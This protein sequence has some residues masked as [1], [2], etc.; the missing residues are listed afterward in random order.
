MGLSD[1]RGGEFTYCAE[2]ILGDSICTLY[3]L[4]ENILGFDGQMASYSEFR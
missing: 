1:E 4:G 2:A 3:G